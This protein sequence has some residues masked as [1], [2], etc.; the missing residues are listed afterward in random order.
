ME[1][2]EVNLTDAGAFQLG[3]HHEMLAT[4][5][6]EDPVYFHPD[7][8][9]GQGFWCITRHADLITVNR[10]ASVFSSA[11][12]GINIPDIDE[13]QAGVRDMMLYMDPPRH[14]RYRL[15]VNK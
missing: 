12:Q 5:R 13:G 1:L 10:D 7:P 8:A 14:T 3:R 6:R 11:A 4:L 15:L 2:N 9:G